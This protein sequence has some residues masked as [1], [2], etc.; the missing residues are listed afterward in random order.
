MFDPSTLGDPQA[1][2]TQWS[3]L[4]PGGANFTT[5]ALHEVPG[6][7]EYRKNGKLLL[8]GAVFLVA[9]L[10]ATAVGIIVLL[11]LLLLGLPFL[12]IGAYVLWPSRVRFDAGSRSVTVAGRTVPFGQIIALQL[13]T[14]RVEGDESADYD[15]HELNLVLSDGSRINVVDHAGKHVLRDDLQRLRALIGCKAWDATR[16]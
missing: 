7:L 16:R 5:H 1:L 11:W 14:E 8:F 15:S 6:G 4:R 12:A 3:P 10:A 13:L 9:G 2:A